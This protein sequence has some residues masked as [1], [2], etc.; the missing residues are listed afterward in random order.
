[1]DEVAVREHRLQRRLGP[2]LLTLYGIGVMVGAGIYVLVGTIAGE[3]GLLAPVAFLIAG[4][5]AAPTALTYAELSVRIPESAGEAAFVRVAFGSRRFSTVVGLIIVAVGS[6]SA[7]AVLRGGVGY[8]GAFVDG[9]SRTMIVVVGLLLVGI[10]LWG[11]VESLSVAAAFTVLEVLGLVLVV[12]AGLVAPPS[13]DWITRPRPWAGDGVGWG[14]LAD[15]VAWG[16][17]AL[18]VVL[19]FF[20]FI[21]FEDMVNL[22]EEVRRPARTMP[23]AIVA[24][25]VTTSL[26]YGL[27]AVA[28]IRSVDIDAL[29]RSDRP[30]ALVYEQVHDS[31]RLLSAI[32]VVAALNGVLAQVVMASRVLFGLGRSGGLPA[33]FHQVDERRGTPTRATVLVGA[34]VVIGALTVELDALAELTSV[35]LLTVFTIMNLALIVIRRRGGSV[36]GFRVPIA[37]PW[38]GLLASLAALVGAVVA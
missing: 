35:F 31:G 5:V 32:A 37:V 18:A 19:A 6:T 28:A 25:L 26:L 22:A 11:V 33:W 38:V 8:L 1:M 10:A 29:G 21:G 2:V 23:I 20:A 12:R 14:E 7:A 24:S 3:A 17:V 4:L 27:V 15:G 9:R 36:A 30:L 13:S 34:A 16:G